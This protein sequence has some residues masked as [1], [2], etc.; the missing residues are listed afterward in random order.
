MIYDR[1]IARL[2]FYK[3][4][5]ITVGLL[6]LIWVSQS[7]RLLDLIITKGISMLDFLSLTFL[8]MPALLHVLIPVTSLIALLMLCNTLT[9]SHEM[10]IFQ[11]SKFSKAQIVKP[12][13]VCLSAVM[14]LNLIVSNVLLPQANRKFH[15]MQAYF[16]NNYI[17]TMIEERT[18]NSD[19]KDVTIYIDNK[20]NDMQFE[21]IFINDSRQANKKLTIFAKHGELQLNNGTP[22]FILNRGIQYEKSAN[23]SR[24]YLTFDT[25]NFNLSATKHLDKIHAIDQA[26]LSTYQLLFGDRSDKHYSVFLVSGLRRIMWP[27]NTLIIGI[28]SLAILINAKFSR[29]HRILP[30]IVAFGSSAFYLI[31]NTVLFGVAKSNLLILY[32]HIIAVMCVA[33]LSVCYLYQQTPR[34]RL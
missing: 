3:F 29:K 1:Y 26:D 8:L 6:M 4:T 5:V 31:C 27:L 9:H 14:L 15:E 10:I 20:V 16:R 30:A 18:F 7:L 2:F 12:F 33:F 21:G 13:V 34:I 22:H 28:L 24:A 23:G 32:P 17:A 19:I 25:Y 11:I